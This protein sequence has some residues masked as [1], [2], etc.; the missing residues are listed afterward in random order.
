MFS[1][2]SVDDRET[3]MDVP[4]APSESFPE[5]YTAG[6]LCTSAP[7][8][9]ADT[10]CEEIFRQFL[11]KTSISGFAIRDKDG[12]FGL[13]DRASFISLFALP[14]RPELY[15]HK[16]IRDLMER[17]PLCADAALSIRELSATIMSR[18]PQALHTGFI[19]TDAGRYAG[20]GKSCFGRWK[21][22][23]RNSVLARMSWFRKRKWLH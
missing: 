23:W 16:P 19:I 12:S 3:A 21:T 10:H 15:G 2:S 11:A 18:Y 14:Y 17:Q 1:I 20:L 8:L 6:M 9:P 13:V 5:S 4:P 22:C 7:L